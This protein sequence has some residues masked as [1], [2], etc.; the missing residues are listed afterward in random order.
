MSIALGMAVR[1][2]GATSPNPAVGCLLYRRD[3]GSVGRIV[4]R[5][6]TQ[7]GGRPH[8]ETEALRRAGELARGATV[9]VTL[10]PCAHHGKTPPCAAALIN[11]GVGR[12]VIAVPD[13]D[14][15]VNGAGIRM[16]E[17]AGIEVVTGVGAIEGAVHLAGYLMRVAD[18]RPLIT[19]KV[20]TSLDGKIA[21]HNG[22]SKWIT[23]ATARARAHLMRASHDGIMV[24]VGTVVADDPELFCRLPGLADRSPIRIIADSRLR[25]PLTA[26][27][28]AGVQ[29]T[30]T[31]VIALDTTANERKR[32]FA[33]VGVEVIEVG[34]NKD[35]RLDMATAV[36]ALGSRGLQSVLV[37]G[38]GRLISSM[39]AA[40][41][42]DRMAWFH[43]PKVIGG[44]G[45]PAAAALGI[46]SLTDAPQFRRIDCQTVGEDI[47]EIYAVQ[48]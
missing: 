45:I 12:V 39:L 43:A 37:E 16:L 27:L 48:A 15:R 31:W 23:G 2:L 46:G 3:L 35:G 29:K 34:P 5:G 36:T 14:V 20:A 6:W 38:G 44:D 40:R 1:G 30:S 19:V 28:V 32:A 7:S 47:L 11:A 8:A 4:G 13:P 24:G 21:L 25:T 41:L 17:S 10:E 9:Y 26:K 42:V 22:R 18:G 33:D